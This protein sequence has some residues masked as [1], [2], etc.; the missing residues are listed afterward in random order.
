MA[1]VDVEIIKTN[2]VNVGM[3]TT[4]AMAMVAAMMV[5]TM[6]AA[7]ADMVAAVDMVVSVAMVAV[8]IRT[9]VVRIMVAAPMK[10]VKYVARLGIL[11]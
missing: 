8:V 10:L 2:T 7:V 6:V 1:A 5:R 11:H 9:M 4:S 3:I